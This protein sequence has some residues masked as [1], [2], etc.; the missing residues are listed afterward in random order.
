M[1]WITPGS[2]L[3]GILSDVRFLLSCVPLGSVLVP[4]FFT[5][6]IRPLGIIAQQYE[7]KYHLF[8]DDT[9]LYISLD[10]G[11]ELKFSCSW[12]SS[13]DDSKP[14]SQPARQTDWQAHTRARA[15]AH[16]YHLWYVHETIFHVL[17]NNESETEEIFE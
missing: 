2:T 12:Y 17:P 10:P 14:S 5:I 16:A 11:N 3:H 9:R 13:I 4:L 6:Y 7:V 8:V 15:Y 1:I